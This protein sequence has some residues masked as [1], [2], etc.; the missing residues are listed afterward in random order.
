MAYCPHCK[1]D[2]TTT[3]GLCDRCSRPVGSSF[4][5]G[6]TLLEGPNSSR[7][8]EPA[9]SGAVRARSPA[10]STKKK[11][12]VYE[13]QVSRRSAAS[14]PVPRLVGW[15]V[16]FQLDC[17]GTDF[18]LREGRNV[19]GA[20]PDQCDL[21]VPSEPSISGRHAVLMYR[22][23]KF[24]I[25]DCDSTNGTYIDDT[26]VFGKG[27]VTVEDRSKIRLGDIEFSLHAI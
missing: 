5:A 14:A 2:V 12:T 24:Q 16:T 15:L 6:A 4:V 7:A 1:T 3:S 25:R 19:I 9:G 11:R 10:G 17:A 22:D 18:R 8:D 26:D 21:V 20:D 27:A 23:G 13:P